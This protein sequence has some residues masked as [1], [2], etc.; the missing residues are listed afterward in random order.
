MQTTVESV[1][2][3]V[4]DMER[5]LHFYT[6]VLDCKV[7]SDREIAGIEFDRLYGLS[8]VRLRT[9]RLGL[10][11]EAIELTEFLTP[12]GRAILSD[13]RSN[14]LWFQHLAIVVRDMEQAYQHLRQH[15]VTQTSP[16]PQTLPKWNSV[17][18]GIQ[19]FYFKDQDGHNL[20]LIHFPEDKGSS[21]WQQPT[22]SLF[23]G[24]DH[25][26]IAVANTAAS[27]AFYCDFLGLKLQ[28]ESQNFGPEQERLSSVPDAQ[29][30]IS[31]LK[32]SGLGVELL[33]YK[34]GQGRPIPADTCANDLWFWQTAIAVED[35]D[36][37]V[38]ELEARQLGGKKSSLFSSELVSA[39]EV[40]SGCHQ[41]FLL[42]DPD[43]H[44]VRLVSI[45]SNS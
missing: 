2:M 16:R 20:E 35:V 42:Q 6:T 30:H 33:E 29:V 8:D 22:Q 7:I 11:G 36:A 10:G 1:G 31:S 40:D 19:A 17:A 41:G 45:G 4:N 15:Q 32:A 38:Q 14:D 13:S 34:S 43:G 3:T 18:G 23:L 25:T 21:K 5:S 9:V 28:Q 27:R 44:R 37:K 39:S 12:K 26:A 24:I